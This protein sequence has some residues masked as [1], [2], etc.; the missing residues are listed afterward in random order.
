MS[1]NHQKRLEG[2]INEAVKKVAL[3]E[4]F[5]YAVSFTFAPPI[6]QDGTPIQGVPLVPSWWVF[7]SIRNSLVGQPD[8]GN[9]FAINGVLPPDD[10]F[11]FVAAGLFQKCMKDREKATGGGGLAGARAAFQAQMQGADK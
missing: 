4:P 8:L 10:A 7:V 6:D 5:G 11:R 9:G 3:T 2:V 1:V